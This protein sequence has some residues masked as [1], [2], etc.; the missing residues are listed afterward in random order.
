M[1][2]GRLADRVDA[3]VVV[4]LARDADERLR[5]LLQLVLCGCDGLSLDV[6]RRDR[7][8][9]N[10]IVEMMVV[11]LM[12]HAGELESLYRANAKFQPVWTP[13][14]ACFQSSA[15][16]P[17]VSVAALRAEA[18]LVAPPWLRGTLSR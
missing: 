2:L 13:R 7:T 17:R 6:M 9:E 8:A 10:G 5:G 4:V 18:F 15:D 14:F 12:A 11:E 1:A 3:R 16:L